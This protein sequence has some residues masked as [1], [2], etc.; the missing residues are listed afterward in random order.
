MFKTTGVVLAIIA[1]MHILKDRCTLLMT[2]DLIEVLT[3]AK[4]RESRFKLCRIG[5]IVWILRSKTL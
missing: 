4:P 2:A 1:S 3:K 5:L